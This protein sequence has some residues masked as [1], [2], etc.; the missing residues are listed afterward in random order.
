[1]VWRSPNLLWWRNKSLSV[2]WLNV[3]IAL[4]F[5]SISN[6]ERVFNG[7]LHA[8]SLRC[9][10]IV[11][12]QTGDEKEAT[13][14]LCT[15]HARCKDLNEWQKSATLKGWIRKILHTCHCKDAFALICVQQL[16]RQFHLTCHLHLYHHFSTIYCIIVLINKETRYVKILLFRSLRQDELGQSK[17]WYVCRCN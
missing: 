12:H 17:I 2:D 7:T 13:N 4:G 15:K 6:G 5:C 14:Y 16:Q 9:Q 10:P 11:N 3:F 8:S 1:M